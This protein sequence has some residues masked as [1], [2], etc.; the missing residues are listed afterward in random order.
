MKGPKDFYKTV[1]VVF[2]PQV[3]SIYAFGA[4]SLASGIE[5]TGLQLLIAVIFTSL[6]PT[7]AL[8][9]RMRHSKV[10]SNVEEKGDRPALLSRFFTAMA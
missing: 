4:L 5:T 7:A 9:A 8:F 6:I 1:S 10:D 2:A 3:S